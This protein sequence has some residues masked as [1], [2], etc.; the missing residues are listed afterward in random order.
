[1]TVKE[2]EILKNKIETAKTNK[3]RAEGALDKI[4]D[5]LQKSF[6]IAVD[7]IDQKLIELNETLNKF[8]QK[9]E[10]LVLKLETICNWDEI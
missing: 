9:K 6:D 4:K 3:A 10:K 1:M 7:G 5:A 2:F 8:K